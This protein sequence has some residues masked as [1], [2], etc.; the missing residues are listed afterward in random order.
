VWTYGG[1]GSGHV[2]T[3]FLFESETVRGDSSIPNPSA[4]ANETGHSGHGVARIT[5]LMQQFSFA[6]DYFR[7]K[8]PVVFFIL[9]PSFHLF[10]SFEANS[11]NF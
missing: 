6:E 1:G 4:A 2:D 9:S 7:L 5:A 10:L 8:V 11:A 3:T